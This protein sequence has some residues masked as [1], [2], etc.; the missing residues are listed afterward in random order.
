M[1]IVRWRISYIQKGFIFKRWK[2]VSKTMEY[3]EAENEKG[4]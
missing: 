1:K 4:N 3:K 2:E